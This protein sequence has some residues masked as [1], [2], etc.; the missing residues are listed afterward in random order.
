[1]GKLKESNTDYFIDDY[2]KTTELIQK[3]QVFE[4]A[5]DCRNICYNQYK[6]YQIDPKT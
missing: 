3:I 6:L 5:F 4:V 2:L 1:M